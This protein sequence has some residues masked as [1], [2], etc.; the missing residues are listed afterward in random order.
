MP[1]MDMRGPSLQEASRPMIVPARLVFA[2]VLVAGTL[3]RAAPA[4]PNV[5]FIAVDDLRPALG[6]YGHPDVQTPHIDRLARRGVVFT[7]AYAQQSVCN[8]S[9]TSM[10]TALRPD[11]T[12]VYDN[13]THFR[14]RRPEAVTLPEQFRRHGYET[15]GIGKIFHSNWDRAYVG[16]QLDDPPS[17]SEPAWFPPAVQFYFTAE[18]QRIA[19]EVYARTAPCPLDGRRVCLHSERA[20]RAGADVNPADPK[21]DDW[22][23]HFIMGP[24][25]EAPEV[26]D[27]LLF[28][29][30]A[31]DR[32]IA[33]LQRVKDRTFFVAVGFSRPHVP[34]V[35]P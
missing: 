18:G 12:G 27:N 15:L 2:G 34:Y 25:T 5:L 8:A 14:V 23:Q 30:Q 3:V 11:T 7:R 32:A 21:Y 26:E 17:W 6:C 20:A 9:R 4:R 28:D 1:G 22:T 31:A 13:S 24:V 35:A 19:R 16:R 29:G 10:L 33:T